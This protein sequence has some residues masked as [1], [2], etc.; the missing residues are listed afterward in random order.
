MSPL[1][2]ADKNPRAH[3][4]NIKIVDGG[5]LGKWRSWRSGS[6]HHQH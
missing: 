1:E 6:A 4:I 3:I 2:G 5:P